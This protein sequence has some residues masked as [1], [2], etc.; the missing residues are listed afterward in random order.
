MEKPI[1]LGVDG[2]ARQIVEKYQCTEFFEP[3]NAFFEELIELKKKGV[4]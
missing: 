1:L 2:Q 4:S 3:E